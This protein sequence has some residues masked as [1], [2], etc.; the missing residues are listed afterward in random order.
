MHKMVPF[1]CIFG[2]ARIPPSQ[3]PP[4]SLP[5]SFKKDLG[6]T[7]KLF[8]HMVKVMP[9]VTPH[10]AVKCFPEPMVLA[11]LAACGAGFDCASSGE[12]RQVLGL[13]GMDASRIIFA[14]PCKRF[15]DLATITK[16]GVPNTTFD[17][18]VELDKIATRCPKVGC[19]VRLRAD[20]PTAR[21]P[22]G[23]KYGALPSE[24]SSLLRH[25]LKLGLSVTGAS[26]HV[27]S[28]AGDPFAFRR[29]IASVRAAFDE[30][31]AID[32]AAAARP[33]LVDLGG[34]FS[35]GFDAKGNAFVSVGSTGPNAVA[36]AINDALDEFFPDEAFPGGLKI[37][38]EPGR[39]FAESSAHIVTRVFGKRERLRAKPD[40]INLLGAVSSSDEEEE[41]K[42]ASSSDDDE[43][44]N[45]GASDDEGGPGEVHY[46][47]SDGIYGG[48]NA[49]VYD[50]WLP[51]AV[52]FRLGPN[53]EA[54]PL[55]ALARHGAPA[56]VFGPT[57]DSLDMVFSRL[58][59][60][61]ELEIGDWLLFPTCGAYTAA[62]A[63][64]FNGIPSSPFTGNGILSHYV[65]SDCLAKT[66]A[67]AKLTRLFNEVGPLSVKK[68][69]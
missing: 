50:G 52:P 47:L 43:E 31:V 45:K 17:S 34:G 16:C 13:P 51:T 12:V 18:H 40:V 30:L 6:A 35:G 54:Q 58:P 64:D 4:P 2:F 20:D 10:Y 5:P 24:V 27:G 44:E 19:V 66:G 29:A 21:M 22:F 59:A 62:G 42:G 33:W 55:T 61:P 39:Y 37:I 41:K 7:T 1:D 46:Y 26:F 68:N 11:T 48:F 69:Y 28:G 8:A 56:T 63:T 9:R 65:W 49:M 60:C 3:P 25:A 36:V 67:D 38:S 53:A 15:C 23:V 14:N 32:P 57:C